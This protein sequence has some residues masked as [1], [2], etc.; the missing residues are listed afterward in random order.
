M[1]LKIQLDFSR[2]S[3]PGTYLAKLE[4][5]RYESYRPSRKAPLAQRIVWTFVVTDGERAGE[6]LEHVTPLEPN[7]AWLLWRTLYALG[8]NTHRLPSWSF[9]YDGDGVITDPDLS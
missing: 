5:A 9:D 6:L 8:M 1:S 4:Q 7:M 2:E 3:V